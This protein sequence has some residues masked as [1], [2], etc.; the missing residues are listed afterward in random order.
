MVRFSRIGDGGSGNPVAYDK[1]VIVNIPECCMFAHGSQFCFHCWYLFDYATLLKN[2]DRFCPLIKNAWCLWSWILE[3]SFIFRESSS[4][5]V[6]V[7]ERMERRCLITCNIWS[8]RCS[9]R[10]LWL[11]LTERGFCLVSCNTVDMTSLLN[12]ELP[13]TLQYIEVRG[14]TNSNI[15]I[16]PLYLRWMPHMLLMRIEYIDKWLNSTGIHRWQSITF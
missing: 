13:Y 9:S 6:H 16:E 14:L 15:T 5:S 10:W 7:V 4:V 1:T 2:S 12:H 11:V 3:G 8:V